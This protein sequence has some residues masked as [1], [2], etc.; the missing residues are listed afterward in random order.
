VNARVFIIPAIIAAFSLVVI[1][2]SLQLELSPAMIVGD[3]MQPRAFPIFLMVINLLLVAVLAYQVYRSP[4]KEIP[5]EG[6][7]TWGSMA[8]LVVF[9]ALTVLL[10]M[11]IGIAVVMFLMCLLWGERR[12]YV[13]A[14]I[15]LVTPVS[16]FFLFDIVLKI[17]FPRGVLTNWYYG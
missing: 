17:R 1:W 10:D 7:A 14:L 3:S 4:P 2:A 8:L 11:F 16:I 6:Y 12:L 13:A 5:L 15:A 9:Y